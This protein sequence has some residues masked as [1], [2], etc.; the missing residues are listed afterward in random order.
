MS[1][2]I[3]TERLFESLISGDRPGAR[4]VI[5]DAFREGAPVGRIAACVNHDH[6]EFHQEKLGSFGFFESIDDEAV[7]H[8][9]F[10][11]AAAWLRPRGQTRIMGP[12][13][14]STNHEAGFLVDAYDLPAVIMMPYNPPYYLRL[15]ESWGLTKEKDLVAYKIEDSP[16]DRIRRIAEKVR[17][18]HH[19]VIP[20]QLTGGVR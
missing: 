2:E 17:N 19:V 10:D 15:A 13:N 12:L 20:G 16:G 1:A 6:N 5:E 4:A 9:L 11:A 7:A 14:F 3:L 8:A 18:R